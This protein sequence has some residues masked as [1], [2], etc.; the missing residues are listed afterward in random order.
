MGVPGFGH[1]RQRW[2]IC[3]SSAMPDIGLMNVPPGLPCAGIEVE[4]RW[5]SPGAIYFRV[6]TLD[7]DYFVLRH[8][9]PQD[10]WSLDAFRSARERLDLP[11]AGQI[12]L[13]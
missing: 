8:D 11:E 2:A 5:Y 3:A 4:D 9:E 13:S 10:V 7:G 1:G 12:G 6:R